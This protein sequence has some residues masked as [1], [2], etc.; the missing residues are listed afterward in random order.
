MDENTSAS[1]STST[2]AT[3]PDNSDSAPATA[4]DDASS[5]P[6]PDN[7]DSTPA[8]ATDDTS[9]DNAPAYN[10]DNDNP[11]NPTK[12]NYPIY[13]AG[14]GPHDPEDGIIGTSD[15]E[16]NN[17]FCYK[18]VES[19]TV[20]YIN[21]TPNALIDTEALQNVIDSVKGTP[22]LESLQA[23]IIALSASI[24]PQI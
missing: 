13:C 12:Q 24:L 2:P 11:T 21:P 14:P 4:P 8:P 6:A 19:M 3:A 7:S 15:R 1:D 22:T 18:C 23:A 17:M 20:E 16:I 9:T 5:T 10:N